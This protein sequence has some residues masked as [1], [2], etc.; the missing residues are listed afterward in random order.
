[1]A[2]LELRATVEPPLGAAL[3]TVTVQEDCPPDAIE[4]GLQASVVTVGTGVLTATE[5]PLP[6]TEIEE[7]SAAAPTALV[8][9]IAA[10]ADGV[11]VMLATVPLAIVPAFSP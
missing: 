5:P 6:N 10:D 11:S 2:L 1:M 4:A 3:D 9:P 7:P 8:T